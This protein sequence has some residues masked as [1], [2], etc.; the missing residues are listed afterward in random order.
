MIVDTSITQVEPDI[1]VF[2]ISGR[3]TLGNTLMGIE[4]S[5]LKLITD[6][7]KKLVVDVAGLDY[8]DS[9]GIGTL[10]GC[11]GQMEQAGGTLCIAGARDGVAQSFGIVHLD[12]VLGL[13]DDLPG[14]C[15]T[16]NS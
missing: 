4:R 5:I 16:F 8:I 1:T 13:H 12:R 9:A 10:I 15:A 11:F 3:L 14:A 7:C 2:A 6:G